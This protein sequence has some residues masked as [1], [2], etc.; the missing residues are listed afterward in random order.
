MTEQADEMPV[1]QPLGPW[2]CVERH[3]DQQWLLDAAERA[4]AEDPQN[5]PAGEIHLTR[6]V[7]LEP[8]TAEAFGALLTGKRWKTGRPLRVRHLGG[9]PEI[10]ARVAT[11]AALWLQHA[12]LT[13]DFGDHA[14]AEI[15]ISYGAD[16]QSWSYVGTDALTVAKDAPTMHFGWLH[17]STDAVETRRV[18]LHEFGH[19][20]GLIHE[21]QHPASA[22]KWNKQAVYDRYIKQLKWTKQ[23]VDS[24]LFATHPAGETQFSTFDPGSIMHYPVPAELTSD[25]KAVGWNTELSQTDKQFIAQIYPRVAPLL[26]A[27]GAPPP[28]LA[29]AAPP[30]TITWRWGC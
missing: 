1:D 9:L 11:Y 15:R 14:D 27:M 25:G 3:L 7:G 22:I 2:V 19:A 10:H 30:P 5:A 17:P 24:N 26:A 28:L 18:V 16:G 13:F 20:L 4:I 12:N 29:A 21:H 8:S 6:R 23:Q